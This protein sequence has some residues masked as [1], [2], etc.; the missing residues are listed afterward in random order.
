MLFLW[1]SA[2]LPPHCVAL[3]TWPGGPAAGWV[4]LRGDAG[5]RL[6]VRVQPGLAAGPRVQTPPRQAVGT[7][8]PNQ[9]PGRGHPRPGDAV[10]RRLLRS[11]RR[12]G[13]PRLAKAALSCGSSLEAALQSMKLGSNHLLIIGSLISLSCFWLIIALFHNSFIFS[14]ATL[15]QAGSHMNN[16]HPVEVKEPGTAHL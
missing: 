9:P 12:R 5:G 13:A 7:E 10:E 6:A 16:Q 4:P 11:A 1:V 2:E 8:L 15:I 3:Q 14:A